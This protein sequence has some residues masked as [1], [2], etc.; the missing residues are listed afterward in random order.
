M[1]PMCYSENLGHNIARKSHFSPVFAI[2]VGNI[3]WSR[4]IC[5][6]LTKKQITR[7]PRVSVRGLLQKVVPK[8]SKPK[9]VPFFIF[10]GVVVYS[11]LFP[12]QCNYTAPIW[13]REVCENLKIL[14][15]CVFLKKSINC[16]FV[17]N[18]HDNV[19]IRT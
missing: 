4:V 9:V 10:Q 15:F 17:T 16:C 8:N 12:S 2:M 5:L 19:P 14:R 11:T 6:H 18:Y 1:Y 7:K 13:K 3:I